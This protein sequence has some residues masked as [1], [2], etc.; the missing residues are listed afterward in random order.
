[1]NRERM[2]RTAEDTKAVL[3]GDGGLRDGRSRDA[4]AE[5]PW[6]SR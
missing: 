5:Q 4:A 3:A 2:L 1:M 6:A